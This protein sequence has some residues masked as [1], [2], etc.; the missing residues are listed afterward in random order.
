M[1]KIDLLWALFQRSLTKRKKDVY[2]KAYRM[3]TIKE[4]E[5]TGFL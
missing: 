5:I 1:I 2:I 4:A 3:R